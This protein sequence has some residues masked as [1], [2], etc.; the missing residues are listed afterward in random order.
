MTDFQSSLGGGGGGGG[1]PKSASS[2]AA[3]TSGLDF[4]GMTTPDGGFSP[5]AVIGLSALAL[6]SFLVL[7][8]I[9]KK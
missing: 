6:V 4:G 3:A 9:A 2:S 7:V 1:A 5:L 8:I